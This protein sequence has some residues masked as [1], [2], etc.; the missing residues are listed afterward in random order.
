MTGFNVTDRRKKKIANQKKYVNLES[1]SILLGRTARVDVTLSNH[2]ADQLI[3][4]KSPL[5][6]YL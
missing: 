3:L 5:S 4:S 6:C 1:G 2:F